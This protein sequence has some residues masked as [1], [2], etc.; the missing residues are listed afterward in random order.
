M[1]YVKGQH[2]EARVM[3][4]GKGQPKRTEAFHWFWLIF[5]EHRAIC[6]MESMV[7]SSHFHP[8]PAQWSVRWRNDSFLVI[9]FLFSTLI[10]SLTLII[11][12]V[13]AIILWVRHFSPNQLITRQSISCTALE[14]A[15]GSAELFFEAPCKQLKA[16]ATCYIP[17]LLL[18][19]YLPLD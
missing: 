18:N 9:F 11:L 2:W 17:A 7:H 3:F 13:R 16:E 15:G 19:F 5:C 10:L 14:S 6:S 8:C 1:L 12:L 4:S